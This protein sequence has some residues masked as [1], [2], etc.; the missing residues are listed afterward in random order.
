MIHV[1]KVS[2]HFDQAHY[3]IV[4]LHIHIYIYMIY[5]YIYIYIYV[6]NSLHAHPWLG[7]IHILKTLQNWPIL[8]KGRCLSRNM[9]PVQAPSSTY[10]ANDTMMVS[11][12]H[13]GASQYYAI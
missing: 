8:T 1:H 12:P 7:A 6:F 2:A 3:H 9:D 10:Y 4:Y 5:I 11:D 13:I